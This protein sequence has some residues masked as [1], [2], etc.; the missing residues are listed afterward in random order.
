MELSLLITDDEALDREGL[1]GQLDWEQYSITKV[2]IAK[3]GRSALDIIKKNN[4]DI[5][6]TDIKMPLMTGIELAQL[7]RE[8]N[9]SLQ[10]VFVSGY[11]DFTYAKMAIHISVYEYLLKPVC[12]DELTECVINMVEQIKEL[13]AE[14]EYRNVLIQIAKDIEKHFYGVNISSSGKIKSNN[15]IA[16]MKI[17][18]YIENHYKENITLNKIAEDLYYTPNYLGYVFKKETNRKFSEY[19]MEYRIRQAAKLLE[20]R[21]IKVIDAA[22]SV[23]YKDMPTFIK[24]FKAV[25]GVTPSEY[26]KYER[27]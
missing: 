10:I 13:R 25:Y 9:P 7:A 17:T 23:G 18:A 19:L 14:E 1:A 24:K 11:D 3:D 5:L 20:E 8:I 21:K 26:R 12:T 22:M 27:Q 4:V 2:F 15:E 16:V 6:F